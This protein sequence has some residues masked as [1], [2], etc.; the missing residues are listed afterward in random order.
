A[1]IT[2]ALTFSFMVA[3]DLPN[4]ANYKLTTS[5]PG[6]KAFYDAFLETM[7]QVTGGPLWSSF[8]VTAIFAPIFEEWMCRGVILRGL[9]T[10]MKPG[11][12]IVIS[13]LFF[14]LIHFNPWQALNAFL[15][16]VIMGYVYYKTGSLLLTMLIHFVNNG[17][18]VIAAQFSNVD[19][20]EYW[21]E[22]M[23]MGTYIPL[24]IAGTAVLAACIWAFHRI[25]LQQKRG[26]IDEIPVTEEVA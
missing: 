10:K 21:I 8:L 24:I 5:T 22:T 25:P 11:W 1:L 2:V 12:A 15:I 6:M 18:A 7:K 14:A 16:G 17:S 9:L 3:S 4:Y 13:A 26:N 23:P 20:T 19:E